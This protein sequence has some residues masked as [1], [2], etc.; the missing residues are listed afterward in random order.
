MREQGKHG[1]EAL[2]Y[3]KVNK[4]NPGVFDLR[5]KLSEIAPQES[6]EVTQDS[7]AADTKAFVALPGHDYVVLR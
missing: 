6:A 5:L 4:I 3:G 7:R 2:P 1:V